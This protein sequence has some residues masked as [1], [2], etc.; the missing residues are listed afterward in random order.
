MSESRINEHILRTIR[1]ET[2]GNK[3]MEHLLISLILKE[4]Q[5]S[6]HWQYKNDYKKAIELLSKEWKK[7]ENK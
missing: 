5:N 1:E 3:T 4:A 2:G 7:G 6:S